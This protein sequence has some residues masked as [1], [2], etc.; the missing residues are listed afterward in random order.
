LQIESAAALLA[1]DLTKL[2][3]DRHPTWVG[4]RV[5]F[6]D[7]TLWSFLMS[8][9]HGAGIMLAPAL[10][11]L[12]AHTVY[13]N[14]RHVAEAGLA[15]SSLGTAATAVAGH[16]G[17]MLLVAG[18]IAVVVYRRLGLRLLSQRVGEPGRDLGGGAH[19]RRNLDARTHSRPI[20]GNV[21]AI[22]TG[23][24]RPRTA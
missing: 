2:V 7:L 13:A 24:R 12:A 14:D 23:S 8:P 11:G 9:A 5:G 15:T 3:R 21:R 20:G 16:S 6:R 22:A 19:R 4:M 18:A 17:A 1:V 10:L